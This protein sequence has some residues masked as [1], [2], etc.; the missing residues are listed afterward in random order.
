MVCRVVWVVGRVFFMIHRVFWV[1][2]RCSE[3]LIG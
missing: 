3:W 2:G 1:V